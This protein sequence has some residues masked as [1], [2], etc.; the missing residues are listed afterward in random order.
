MKQAVQIESVTMLMRC[1]IKYMAKTQKSQ[2]FSGIFNFFGNYAKILCKQ[3]YVNFVYLKKLAQPLPAIMARYS[4]RSNIS[5]PYLEKPPKKQRCA[6][7]QN[8]VKLFLAEFA[9]SLFSL[10]KFY[11]TVFYHSSPFPFRSSSHGAFSSVGSAP[12]TLRQPSQP[13]RSAASSR[14]ALHS[15]QEITP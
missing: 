6:Q 14:Q 5:A 12:P 3:F 2:G 8:S 10:C 1:V 4:P 11:V 7:I 13:P 15:L 9:F